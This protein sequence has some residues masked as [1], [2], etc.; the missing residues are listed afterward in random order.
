VSAT[1]RVLRRLERAADL[2]AEIKKLRAEIVKAKRQRSQRVAPKRKAGREKKRQRR[3]SLRQRRRST[4]A[5]CE[6]RAGGLCEIRALGGCSGRLHHDHFFGRGKEKPDMRLEWM[7]CEAH[8]HRKTENIPSRA[9]WLE[10]FKLHAQSHG[11]EEVV[12]KCEGAIA[13]EYAQHKESA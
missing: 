3:E 7:L 11:Y 5:E 2:E 8:H 9:S 13:L 10:L 12:A 6:A 1:E 4:R